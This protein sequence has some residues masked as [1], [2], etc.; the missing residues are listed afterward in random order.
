MLAA[1]AGTSLCATLLVTAMPAAALTVQLNGNTIALSPQPVQRA[2]RVFVPLRGVFERM[3]ATVVYANGQINAT[4]R[5]HNVSLTIG[6]RTAIVDGQQQYLDVAPFII[7]ASTYVP[8]RFVSQ[9]LGATVNWDNSNQIVAIT[10]LGGGQPPPP[11]YNPPPPPAVN[12]NILRVERPANGASVRSD[13]PTISADFNATIDANSL[14]IYVDGVDVTSEA[15]RSPSGFIFSP[16]SSLQAIQHTVRVTG[17][18]ANG[19]EF[20]QEWAFT[21]GTGNVVVTP[22]FLNLDRPANG[23]TVGA[24][25]V[26]H[27]RTLPGA[28]VHI[29]AGATATFGVFAFGAGNYAADVTADS[30]GY[31]EQT[32]QLQTVSGASI[33]LTVTDARGNPRATVRTG[34]RRCSISARSA[35]VGFSA[36]TTK[37]STR[38]P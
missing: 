38:C 26:V 1:V 33:G 10:A 37:A 11:V 5:G 30:N 23:A 15:T 17:R 18:D 20:A 4:G 8:L 7:G 22:N 36:L 32:V 13:R 2:G 16:P 28:H 29:A 31:F 27:G 14:R 35:S 19:V 3:G 34:S 24:S 6:Q 25:F 9:A 21:S 12:H